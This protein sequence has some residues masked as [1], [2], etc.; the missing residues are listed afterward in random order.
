MYIFSQIAVI[1]IAYH[2]NMRVIYIDHRISKK[3]FSR[4]LEIRKIREN[5]Y[6]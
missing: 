4:T 5:K 1:I 6:P 2:N 3:I